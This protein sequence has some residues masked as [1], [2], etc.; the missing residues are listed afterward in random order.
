MNSRLVVLATAGASLVSLALASAAHAQS[1]HGSDWRQTD[2]TDAASDTH[3]SQS[4]AFE[5]RFGPYYP[6][7]DEEFDLEVGPYERA[8]DDDPQ[9]YFGVE[10][11]WLPLRIPYVGAFGPGLGWGYTKTSNEAKIEGTNEDS[12]EETALT[13]LP[14]HLSAVLR[15][16]ELMRRT[17]VPLVPYIKG[18]IGFATWDATISSGT[19]VAGGTLGRDTTWGFHFALG[20]MLSL[21]F[22]DPGGSRRLDETVGINHTYVF[23]EWMNAALDGIGSRPQMHVGSSSWVVGLAVDL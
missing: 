10:L 22:I 13:I 19:R 20:G 1:I 12:A 21:N 14:M 5:L 17:G 3:S 9:F 6:Q 18:G 23:G 15:A 7:I 8:F 11:D 4:F 2:R 16:D